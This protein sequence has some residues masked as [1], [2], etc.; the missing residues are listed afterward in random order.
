MTSNSYL[1]DAKH[2]SFEIPYGEEVLHDID[3]SLSAGQLLGVLGVNGAGKTALI[4]LLL[5]N[6]QIKS[7]ELSVLGEDPY[8]DERKR[9]AEIGYISQNIQLYQGVSVQNHLKFFS[10]FFPQY[11]KEKEKELLERLRVDPKR[12][13]GG[14]SLGQ[15]KKVQVISVLSAKPRLLIV[16]EITAVFDEASRQDFFQVINEEKEREGLGILLATNIA[17][18]LANYADSVL[19]VNQGYSELHENIDID[20]IFDLDEVA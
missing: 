18:D 11:S 9:R 10:S 8:Q 19:F 4:N 12:N 3:F 2:I 13:I 14:L 6:T 5:G 16:D 15:K 1:I 20:K 7:G 17:K